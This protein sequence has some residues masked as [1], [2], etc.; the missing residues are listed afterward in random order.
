MGSVSAAVPERAVL[1]GASAALAIH[2]A[3]LW[4]ARGTRR[5]H[6]IGRDEPRLESVAADLRARA[7]GVEVT[8]AVLDLADPTTIADEVARCAA[9]RPDVV[10][11]AHGAMHPQAALERDLSRAAE[12]LI[13]TGV[14]PT[15]WLEGFADALDS[16]TL[17]IIGSVAGD[18]GRSSNLL[19]GAAKAMIEHAAQGLQHRFALTRRGPQIVLVKPGPTRTPMTA[20]LDPGRLADPAQVAAGIA[21]A[22]AKG[23]PVTYL[24][25]K[26]RPIM[27]VVRSIPRRIFGRI[28]L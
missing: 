2:T 9:D 16:G 22:V 24:P 27:F 23:T 10:L 18:R 12:Q 11:I 19:Y 26:W 7:D 5:L 20:L 4:V 8:I 15:L 13:V 6:L 1:V 25:W 21:A 14:S 17:A 28:D 3:R